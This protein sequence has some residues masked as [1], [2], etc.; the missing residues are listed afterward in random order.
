MPLCSTQHWISCLSQTM[1]Q[2][3]QKCKMDVMD[4]PGG[5]RPAVAPRGVHYIHY[6]N[7]YTLPYSATLRMT[8]NYRRL[9]SRYCNI[10]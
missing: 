2:H 1:M 3:A 5:Y 7:Q 10:E 8:G 6:S 4:Y 9:R